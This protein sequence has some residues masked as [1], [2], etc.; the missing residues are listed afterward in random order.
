[1]AAESERD[2][3]HRDET[4]TEPPADEPPASEHEKSEEPGGPYGNPEADEE[5]LRKHQEEATERSD[6][7]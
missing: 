3:P 4:A 1:M 2:E 6:A 7:G 5:A